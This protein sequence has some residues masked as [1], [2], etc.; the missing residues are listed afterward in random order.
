MTTGTEGTTDRSALPAGVRRDLTCPADL[1]AVELLAAYRAGELSPVETIESVLARVER[2]NPALNAFCLVMADEARVAARASEERWRR[3][4]PRGLL[5]GVPASIKD[6]MLTRGHPTLRGSRTI[7]PKGPWPEDSPAVARLREHGAVL[8]GKTT[9]PELAWKGVTDSPLTGVTRNPWDLSR[10]PGGSSGGA[11]VAVARGM[12]PLATGTDGGGSVRIPASFTGV[13]ALKPTYGLVPHYPASAFGTLAHS[14]P[15]TRTVAD[16]ALMLDVLCGADS[17]DWAALAR[18]AESFARGLDR[19][20]TGMRVAFSP[21][22]GHVEVDPDVAGRV[23]AAAAVFDELGARVE[24]VDP[25]FADPVGDFHVLWFSGA[26]K[27]TEALDE[28]RRA[29]LDPGL[30]EI[31]EEGLT[32]SA[33]DYLT[34]MATRMSLG[35]L[36]GRFH[37]TYDLLLTPATAI[38]A[39]EAGRETPRRWPSRRWTSWAGFSY[40]FN[41]TQQP[42]ASLPCG[43]TAEGLPVGL[44]IVGARHADGLV[45]AAAR[46]F[47]RARPQEWWPAPPDGHGPART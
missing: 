17:R 37:D 33:Q 18:P 10:T 9:T 11:A 44:Q 26:A 40:P 35:E 24:P 14:G 29:L 23:A 1:T 46:A 28:E 4:E 34:A 12:G 22:L 2:E 32:Y 8:F 47:E 25:G 13:V 41:L 31:V 43:F 36:M 15:M 45:L 6:V 39:F 7:D 42:A 5:D 20:L 3:G 16:A 19:P 21:T 38:P 30:R 27:A